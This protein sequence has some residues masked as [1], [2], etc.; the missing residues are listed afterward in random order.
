ME[1]KTKIVS[2]FFKTISAKLSRIFSGSREKPISGSA[3]VGE[4]KAASRSSGLGILADDLRHEEFREVKKEKI[5]K[6]SKRRKITKKTIQ[7]LEK[8]IAD[9]KSKMSALELDLANKRIGEEEYQRKKAETQLMLT[10]AEQDNIGEKKQPLGLH[11]FYAKLKEKVD[12]PRLERIEQKLDN[13]M[14]KHNVDKEAIAEH[15]ENVDVNKVLKSIDNLA[16]MVELEKKSKQIEK[17]PVVVEPE[18]FGHKKNK[19]SIKTMAVEI[20][21]NR[22][23]TELDQILSMVQEKKKVTYDD[24]K[25]LGISQKNFK[26]YAD[27]LKQEGLVELNYSPL[28]AV[29]LK[30][31][32]NIE[33]E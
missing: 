15:A 29:Y 21:K 14:D 11:P 27:I 7:R 4:M 30:Y 28:G 31:V 33:E 1:D 18:H 20:K 22:I 16:S 13:L 26:E 12:G 8:T 2:N 17:L 3:I 23:I 19:E 9:L 32:E 5:K 24:V 6:K 10:Q 25:S